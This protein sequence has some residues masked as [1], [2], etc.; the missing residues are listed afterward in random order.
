MTQS[1]VPTVP[2][3]EAGVASA[4]DGLVVLDGPSGVAVTMTAEAATRTAQSLIT[5]AQA[6]E[7]QMADREGQE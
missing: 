4:E 1:S 5:A 3:S 7:Q 6:A 2:Q